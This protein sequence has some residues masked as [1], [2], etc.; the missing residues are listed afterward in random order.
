MGKGALRWLLGAAALAAVVTAWMFVAPPREERVA[1][2]DPARIVLV[3]TPGGFL[4]VGA[5][6]KVEEFGWSSRYT[7]PLIDCPALL[8]P[9]ISRVRVRA[10][11]VYR[12]PLAAEWKLVPQG[13]H[14]LLTVP[15]PQLQVPVA[16]HTGDLQIHTESGWLSPPAAANR[17]AVIKHLGPELGRRGVD[18]AYLQAQRPAAEKTVQEFARKWMLEQ[19]QKADKPVKVEFKA[20]A[21]VE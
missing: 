19:G 15:E 3:R 1:V 18:P 2:L 5:L 13:D 16:F 10:H 6:E 8:T 21:S 12:V 4:E 9:T 14:Y 20:L 17:E 7:C 11:Y